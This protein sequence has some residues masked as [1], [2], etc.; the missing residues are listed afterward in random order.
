MEKQPVQQAKTVDEFL[1]DPFYKDL[2]KDAEKIKFYKD[3]EVFKKENPNLTIEQ[4]VEHFDNIRGFGYEEAKAVWME[5]TPA[6]RRLVIAQP[7]FALITD[8]VRKKAHD[9]T[10]NNYGYSGAGDESDAFRHA[11]WNLLM[12]KYTGKPWAKLM[13]DAH[14]DKT[15]E[16]FNKVFP[17]GFTG[18][19][20]TQMDLHNNE[21]GRD[22]WNILID[23]FNYFL[24]DGDLQN[25]VI[26]KIRAGEM[27]KLHD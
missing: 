20:H 23:P 1:T 18:R 19:Q 13:A 4:I 8:S 15:E 24:T 27:M 21:K 9:Y 16:Y 11:V 22:C 3:L 10:V 25:R 17:D 2:P 12:C 6:E 14:E 7:A 26:A 5:L